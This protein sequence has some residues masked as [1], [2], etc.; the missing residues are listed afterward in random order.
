MINPY[1]KAAWPL[2]SS[3]MPPSGAKETPPPL[4]SG[5][6]FQLSGYLIVYE[7]ASYVA[8]LPEGGGGSAAAP[9]AP[10]GCFFTIGNASTSRLMASN[11]AE[12]RLAFG[13]T[14]PSLSISSST[15]PTR[16]SGFGWSDK[17]SG[18][19]FPFVS[20]SSFSKN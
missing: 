15:R 13:G 19:F 10:G 17:N 8:K 16:C 7:F 5:Y 1:A 18:G 6:F 20:A 4:L 12:S 11:S 3:R 9:A 2:P 14:P